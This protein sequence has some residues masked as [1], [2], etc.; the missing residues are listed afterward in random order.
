MMGTFRGYPEISILNPQ[1]RY[2]QKNV[3]YPFFKNGDFGGYDLENWVW[4]KSALWICPNLRGVPKIWGAAKGCPKPVVM[5]PTTEALESAI[6]YIY[7]LNQETWFRVAYPKFV[8]ERLGVTGGAIWVL[9]LITSP[10]IIG[11]IHLLIRRIRKAHRETSVTTLTKLIHEL[12]ARIQE[13]YRVKGD[14]IH[15][16]WDHKKSKYHCKCIAY[17]MSKVIDFG[18]HNLSYCKW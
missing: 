1:M 16:S 2:F 6:G 17:V 4:T 12:P 7:G 3:N 10:L 14:H 13:I 9:F 5:K 18:N 8:E 11:T 15:P